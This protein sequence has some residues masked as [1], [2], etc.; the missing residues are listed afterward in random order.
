MMTSSNYD[1]A[2]DIIIVPKLCSGTH[3]WVDNR[4]NGRIF[5]GTRTRS[6]WLHLWTLL[7]PPVNNLTSG[8]NDALGPYQVQWDVFTSIT[9]SNRPILFHSHRTP[10]RNYRSRPKLILVGVPQRNC[11]FHLILIALLISGTSKRIIRMTHSPSYFKANN[12]HK[13]TQNTR[14]PIV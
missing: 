8:Q 13:N 9:S 14:F 6:V 11:H 3:G 10:N 7:A 12:M 4:H 2:Q 5:W 1:A